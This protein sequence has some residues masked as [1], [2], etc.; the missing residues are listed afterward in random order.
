MSNTQ[1]EQLVKV[2]D[3]VAAIQGVLNKSNRDDVTVTPESRLDDLDLTSLDEGE[4][5]AT[6]EENLG[7]ELDPATAEDCVTV[8]DLVQLR[9]L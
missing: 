5:F 2:E 7:C 8:G 3:V 1:T 4:V 6:L 9:P